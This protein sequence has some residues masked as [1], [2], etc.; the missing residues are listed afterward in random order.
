MRPLFVLVSIGLSL[1]CGQI[2]PG[3]AARPAPV[4]E[5]PVV[6]NGGGGGGGG[7]YSPSPIPTSTSN[8]KS[9]GPDEYH[10]NCR[11]GPA[12]GCRY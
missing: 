12:A 1:G 7:G 3:A 2:A 6:F 4:V 8:V 5:Q 9:L 11:T 10:P